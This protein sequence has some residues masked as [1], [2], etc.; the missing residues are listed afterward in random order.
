METLADNWNIEP[1]LNL[2]MVENEGEIT[3]IS[4]DVAPVAS[5]AVEAT[6]IVSCSGM[7]WV[8]LIASCSGKCTLTRV[9]V[10]NIRRTCNIS[11]YFLSQYGDVEVATCSLPECGFC[12]K[13]DIEELGSS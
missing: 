5:Q 9:T 1:V 3:E 13:K 7:F 11:Q 12:K 10:G 4:E 8:T 2:E 6:K